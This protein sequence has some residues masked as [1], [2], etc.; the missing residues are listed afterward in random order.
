MAIDAFEGAPTFHPER[1]ETHPRRRSFAGRFACDSGTQTRC[2][3][4]NPSSIPLLLL[5]L[6][7]HHRRRIH[8]R[9][10]LLLRRRRPRHSAAATRRGIFRK[11]P[12][13]PNRIRRRK[14]RDWSSATR[15]TTSRRCSVPWSLTTGSARTS[16]GTTASVGGWRASP[17]AGETRTPRTRGSR[18]R[19]RGPA[20]GSIPGPPD[21]RR[22][23]YQPYQPY[24]PYRLSPC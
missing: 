13:R 21:R 3:A 11:R 6:R 23:P 5:P 1:R 14:P 17:G 7:Y 4:R 22:G 24:Q 16:P 19:R 12:V 15:L 20:A 9:R 8:H 10:H 18:R 2:A